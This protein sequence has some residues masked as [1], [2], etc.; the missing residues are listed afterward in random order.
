MGALGLQPPSEETCEKQCGYSRL[1]EEEEERRKV[2]KDWTL[3]WRLQIVVSSARNLFVC[4]PD[5]SR[6]QLAG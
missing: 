1:E 2:S 4:T 6:L 3:R 5:F